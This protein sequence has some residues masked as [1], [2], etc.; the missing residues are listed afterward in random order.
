MI[1]S[2]KCPV[3]F[4][5]LEL[6]DLLAF[7]LRIFHGFCENMSATS[8]ELE[9]DKLEQ[10]N[11]QLLIEVYGSNS[12]DKVSVGAVLYDGKLARLC[13]INEFFFEIEQCQTSFSSITSLGLRI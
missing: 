11:N 12:S 8:F 2:S 9:F 3:L 13:S 5:E 4:L 1:K 6:I 7:I 10:T